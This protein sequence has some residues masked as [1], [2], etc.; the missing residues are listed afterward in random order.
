VR[1][2]T[3]F[4]LSLIACSTRGPGWAESALGKEGASTIKAE[5]SQFTNA[6]AQ[7]SEPRCPA[8]LVVLDIYPETGVIEFSGV[9]AQLP[10]AKMVH[11]AADVRCLVLVQHIK[12]VSKR[13]PAHMAIRFVDRSDQSVRTQ[14][15][16]GRDD[17]LLA[18][19]K[20]L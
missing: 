3:A 16:E 19:L 12:P 1:V 9:S 18:Y 20:K 7:E 11:A 8:P 13:A 2:A 4:A 15:I 14:T 5:A 17:E 10:G 6:P